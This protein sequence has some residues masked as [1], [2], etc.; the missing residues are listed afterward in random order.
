M[1]NR[2]NDEA[3]P[4]FIL[5]DEVQL[6]ITREELKNKDSFVKLYGILNGLLRKNNV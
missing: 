4:Y 3:E 6:L 2:T 5:L 1:Q